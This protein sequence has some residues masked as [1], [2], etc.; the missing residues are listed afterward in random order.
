MDCRT[1]A[2]A[3]ITLEELNASLE[4][5]AGRCLVASPGVAAY[6]E[7]L[8]VVLQRVRPHQASCVPRCHAGLARR[9]LGQGRLVQ[10][11]F[12]DALQSATLEQQPGLERRTGRERQPLQEIAAEPRQRD[13]FHP[14]GCA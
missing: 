4:L 3:E 11:R 5:L 13:C 7:F 10:H 1:W 12:G 2:N 8:E 14:R 9:Q 6:E